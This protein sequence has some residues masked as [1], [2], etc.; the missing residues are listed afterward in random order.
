MRTSS[1]PISGTARVCSWIVSIPP[2]RSIAAACMLVGVVCFIAYSFVSTQKWI[3]R[4]N[5]IQPAPNSLTNIFSHV[6]LFV[7]P[8]LPLSG[9]RSFGVDSTLQKV[10]PLR[11]F[12]CFRFTRKYHDAVADI[13]ILQSP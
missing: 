13:P 10:H 5:F 1:G 8:S 3:V 2:N 9:L 6:H 11:Y 7:T 12:V 4:Y